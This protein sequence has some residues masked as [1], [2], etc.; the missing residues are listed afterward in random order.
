MDITKNILLRLD[1]TKIPLGLVSSLYPGTISFVIF[2]GINSDYFL[3]EKQDNVS[4]ISINSISSCLEIL[5]QCH[6]TINEQDASRF[7]F[8]KF[9][10]KKQKIFFLVQ[11]IP[12]AIQKVVNYLI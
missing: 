10:S 4:Q 9:K 12:I 1:K 3:E 11:V 6:E 2:L 5:T 7:A 8:L